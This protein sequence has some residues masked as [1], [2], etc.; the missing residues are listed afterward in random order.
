MRDQIKRS[1]PGPSKSAIEKRAL[2]VLYLV[3]SSQHTAVTSRKQVAMRLRLTHFGV[4]SQMMLAWSVGF[5]SLK[6]LC[7]IGSN[8]YSAGSACTQVLKQKRMYEGQRDQLFNQQFNLEQVAFTTES[9]KDTATTV[10]ALKGAAKELKTQMKK[11]EYN[12]D[13][14]DK[15]QDEMSDLMVNIL[16]YTMPIIWVYLCF[17]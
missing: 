16:H 13:K 4:D 12:I 6:S 7:G 2:Q 15:L 11:S 14:I 9:V 10:Q 1:R 17:E 8:Y 3:T 5:T